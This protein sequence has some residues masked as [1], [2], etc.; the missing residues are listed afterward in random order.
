[1]AMRVSEGRFG[2]EACKAKARVEQRASSVR[3]C[4][5]SRQRVSMLG[6]MEG[7]TW[8][9]MLACSARDQA[10]PSNDHRSALLGPLLALISVLICFAIRLV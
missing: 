8:S 6:R 10:H 2:G 3:R 5:I 9:K 4:S 7:V 1:M